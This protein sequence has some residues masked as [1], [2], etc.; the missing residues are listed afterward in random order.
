[1]KPSEALLKHRS[2]VL[3]LVAKYPV[4]NP[5]VFGSVVHGTDQEGSDLDILV[6]S[7]PNTNLFH[8]G[9]LQDRLQTL[10]NIPVDLVTP[11]DLPASFR[12]NVLH[13]AKP[14]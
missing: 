10:L 7:L 4:A 11:F 14:I 8:L 2:E 6:D 3:A 12:V 9:G 5:R 13:E 1:M